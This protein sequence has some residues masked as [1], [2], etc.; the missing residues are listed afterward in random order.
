MSFGPFTSLIEAPNDAITP[1]DFQTVMAQLPGL[2][3]KWA[4]E[5]N[6]ALQVLPSLIPPGYL[7]GDRA[8][9]ANT[10][11]PTYR[12]TAVYIYQ[13]PEE[14]AKL[15]IGFDVANAQRELSY[16]AFSKSGS[17]AAR[18]IIEM[19]NMDELTTTPFDLDILDARF[20]CLAC[21]D[22]ILGGYSGKPALTWRELVQAYTL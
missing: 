9:T 21:P 17:R 20:M 6:P 11:A 4:T 2:L 10:L 14:V 12:A 16:V 1:E 7:K 18:A 15:C 5:D 19:L 8:T 13:E 3:D 22:R